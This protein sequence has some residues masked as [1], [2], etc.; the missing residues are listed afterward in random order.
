M[1]T[2][3]KRLTESV[4][5]E[6]IEDKDGRVL[7]RDL[8]VRGLFSG[9]E[10]MRFGKIRIEDGFFIYTRHMM[11]NSIPVQD[12]VWGY[13]KTEHEENRP[14]RFLLSYALVIITRRR[15]KYEFEMPEKEAEACIQ[16]LR[17]LNREF[18]WGRPEGGR[19]PL[20][21][22]P[23]I[24][25]CGAL[26]TIDDRQVLPHRLLFGGDLYHLSQTDQRIL[27]E[28]YH[29]KKVIDF[30]SGT[31]ILHRPDTEMPGVEYYHIPILDEEEEEVLH[32]GNWQIMTDRGEELSEAQMEELYENLAVD[33]YSVRQ[34]ALFLDVL[35][36]ND[37][38]AV[39]WHGGIGK[40]RTGVATALLLTILGVPRN[41]I[42]KT[43]LKSNGC[44]ADEE[45]FMRRMLEGKGEDLT[46][47]EQR[48][49][50]FYTVDESYLNR[51][52]Y[53]LNQ[54][55]GSMQKF[56]S[57]ELLLTPKEIDQL[58]ERYLV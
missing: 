11:A 19:I 55:Y 18:V 16:L 23:N 54:H 10:I 12:I 13:C 45:R 47:H 37:K 36:K 56:L 58:K 24:R 1:K 31:E 39:L 32:P 40:D 5:Y 2:R 27:I 20:A 9:R 42:R 38:G 49:K 33:R 57:E 30:R 4:I 14:E 15:K 46:L 21:N 22:T 48:L 26:S 35:R 51:Y 50:N 29:L 53:R 34:F 44:L 52:F 25:D 17:A 6:R 3:S 43:Y 7:Q 41:T 8:H 28:D